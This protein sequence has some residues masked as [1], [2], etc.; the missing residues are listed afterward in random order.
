LI[1][2]AWLSGHIATVGNL[3][4]SEITCQ[5]FSSGAG[6][7]LSLGE[8][9]GPARECHRTAGRGACLPEFTERIAGQKS[10]N[11]AASWRGFAG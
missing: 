7:A 10:Q 5:P 4:L 2:D 1:V 11:M 8:M 3:Q 6:G 9:I